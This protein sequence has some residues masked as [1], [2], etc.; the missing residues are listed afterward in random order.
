MAKQVA[1]CARI[2][3]KD[4]VHFF[5]D[6]DG[7]Q[8]NV[9]QVADR[10]GNEIQLRHGLFKLVRHQFLELLIGFVAAVPLQLDLQFVQ[11]DHRAV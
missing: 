9:L 10:R 6:A 11:V 8:G 4:A 7:T 5:Q 1:R 3:S 2:F